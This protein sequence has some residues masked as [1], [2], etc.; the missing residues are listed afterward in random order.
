MTTDRARKAILTKDD[1]KD[2]SELDA[3]NHDDCPKTFYEIGAEDF[4]N[5]ELVFSTVALPELSYVFAHPIEL[6]QSDM[7]GDPITPDE[8]KSHFAQC[9]A[10]LIHVS[11]T[12]CFGDVSC[13][14][15]STD[16][17]VCL[18]HR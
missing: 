12:F 17:T 2:R 10:D 13:W 4:N 5:P 9:R 15:S 7:P 3:R 1:T 8:V 6:Q 18:S 11:W 14:C 16:R